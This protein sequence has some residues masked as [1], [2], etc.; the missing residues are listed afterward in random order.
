MKVAVVGAGPAGSFC[1]YHLSRAGF[2]VTLFDFHPEAWEK[3]CGGGVPPK[4]RER[5]AEV[6]AYDGKRQEVAVGNFISPRGV[7]V[8]LI[9]RRAM[10]IVARREFDGYL[11]KLAIQAGA[12]LCVERVRHV[13]RRGSG[14]SLSG[15]KSYDFDFIVGADGALSI[16]RRDLFQPIPR[17]YLCMAQGYFLGVQES[18]ATS[19]FL[20]KPGYL[21]AFPRTDH[22]CLGGGTSDPELDMWA[23]VNELKGRR[24]PQ[25]KVLRK[26]AAPIPFIRDPSFYQL[27]TSIEGC[28]LIGDAA[29][30]VDA[31][32]GEGILYALWGGA[33]LAQALM[34]G[35][36]QQYE[37][38][39]RE[40]YGRELGK[41]SEFSGR[42]YQPRMIERVFSLA[43]RSRTMRRLLMDLM[44]DQPSYLETGKMFTRRLPRITVEL[45][46]SLF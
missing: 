28:A 6:A 38:A 9:S 18:E 29:G 31:L 4:V 16:V 35:R 25:A 26:W 14:F 7:A 1:A 8:Q 39:W 42:F 44:T 37:T 32:T 22:L 40:A 21:W 11:R 5:F 12:R 36:P 13:E 3:P 24:Y 30:H 34:D 46:G 15:D 27:P 10:W 23:I 17:H 45:I 33:L 2:D 19:W 41:A 20:Q 43:N